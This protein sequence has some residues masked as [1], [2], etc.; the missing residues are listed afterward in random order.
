MVSYHS[1]IFNQFGD[2]IKSEQKFEI[3]ELQ[4]IIKECK[5]KIDNIMKE[6]ITLDYFKNSIKNIDEKLNEEFITMDYFKNF[7][8]NLDEKLN[9]A[10]HILF[11]KLDKSSID[12]NQDT[13]NNLKNEI[14]DKLKVFESK[15]EHINSLLNK[16]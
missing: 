14:N 4:N 10:I 15:I 8:K 5:H 11:E 6:S 9:K 16:T 12:R 13:Y 3:D 2:D 1:L 7:M